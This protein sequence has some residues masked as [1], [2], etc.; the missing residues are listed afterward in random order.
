MRLRVMREKQQSVA[1]YAAKY[2]H[3]IR[4]YHFGPGDVV[5]VRNTVDEDSLSARNRERWWGPVIVVRRTRGGAYIVCE[6]NGA[7]WQKKIGQFRVIPYEQ[8]K[9]LTL[10]PRIEELLDISTEALDEL[11]REPETDLEYHGPDFQFDG[12]SLRRSE[13]SAAPVFRDATDE[14][15]RDGDGFQAD[16]EPED[17]DQEDEPGAH[18]EPEEEV[19]EDGLR[20]SKRAPKPRQRLDL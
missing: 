18:A 7:V 6:F 19:P 20:R 8:R 13:S 9:K 4:D 12:V 5:L 1:E 16:S 17:S 15:Q 14:I 3:V 11:E 10:G 2:R